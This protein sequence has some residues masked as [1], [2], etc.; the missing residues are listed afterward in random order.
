MQVVQEEANRPSEIS[1]MIGGQYCVLT[2]R[3][4]SCERED[5]IN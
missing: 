1:K 5:G 3:N 4:N 2:V